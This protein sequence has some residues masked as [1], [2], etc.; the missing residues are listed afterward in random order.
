MQKLPPKNVNNG[1]LQAFDS[2]ALFYGACA[3]VEIDEY[4]NYSK[5]QGA[6]AESIKCL[7]R[8]PAADRD[9]AVKNRL[10]QFTRSL[11]LVSR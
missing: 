8:I 7:N 4:Q 3:D 5:A 1:L 9:P 10:D 6:L 2:L 11:D